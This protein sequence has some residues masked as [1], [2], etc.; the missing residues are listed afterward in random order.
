MKINIE[1][2]GIIKNAEI[3]LSDDLIIFTG[4]NNTGKTY[5]NYILYGLYRIPYGRIQKQFY[6]LTEI[7]DLSTDFVCLQANLSKL[8]TEK[9]YEIESIYENLLTEFAPAIFDSNEIKPRIKIS[10]DKDKISYWLNS[11]EQNFETEMNF[12]TGFNSVDLREDIGKVEFIDG[13]LKFSFERISK[14]HKQYKEFK[15]NLKDIVRLNSYAKFE[16]IMNKIAYFSHIQQRDYSPK[17]FFFVAERG[18]LNQFTHDIIYSKAEKYEQST[19]LYPDETENNKKAYSPDY[20]LAVNDYI[21]LVYN[22]KK[23]VRHN[24]DFKDLAFELEQSMLDKGKVIVD[25]NGLIK[26]QMENEK[27][28]AIHETS[29]TIK[30]LAGFVLYLRHMAQKN[31][32]IFIDEPELNLHPKNQIKFARLLAKLTNKGI[33]VILSTHSDFITKEFSSLILLHGEKAS[34]DKFWAKYDLNE[35]QFLDKDKVGLYY[36]MDSKVIRL[37]INSHGLEIDGFD[38]VIG[39]QSQ[40]FDNIYFTVSDEG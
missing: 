20:P 6:P 5:L 34:E 29:S 10:F 30:S 11:L 35:E 40:M 23:N 26:F 14:T 3:D 39:A 4:Y 12:I 28:I 38:D 27:T 24:S 22:L 17:S 9:I 21:K 2:L 16:W 32:V 7:E 1:N 33:K 19:N 37:D 15:D 25:E 8:F 31:D 36:F 13:G 18:S